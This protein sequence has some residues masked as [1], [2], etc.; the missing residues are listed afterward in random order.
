M[1]AFLLICPSFRDTGTHTDLDWV[2]IERELTSPFVLIEALAQTIKR[3][4]SNIINPI[5]V[6][7]AF[8]LE[9]QGHF[10]KYLQIRRCIKEGAP[11]GQDRA[12]V[13]R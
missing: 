12:P 8:S 9:G 1:L 3:E 7:I 10:W 6:F 5:A 2:L 4:K 13:E 11:F